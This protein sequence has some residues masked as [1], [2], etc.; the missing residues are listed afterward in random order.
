MDF[1]PRKLPAPTCKRCGARIVWLNHIRGCKVPVNASSARKDDKLF[2]PFHM[3]EK[4]EK[5]GNWHYVSET[6]HVLHWLTCPDAIAFRGGN[7]CREIVLFR[8][9]PL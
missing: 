3:A 6:K 4:R 8:P 9:Q 2:E 5:K 1:K 7:P